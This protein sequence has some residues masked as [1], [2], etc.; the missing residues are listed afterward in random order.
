LKLTI[1]GHTGFIGSYFLR[2]Q[3]SEN[4]Q[5]VDK[6]LLNTLNKFHINADSYAIINFIGKA[7]DHKNTNLV[8]EYY[9]VNTKLSNKLFDLFL[10]SNANVFITLS[11]VKAAADV[12]FDTILTEDHT[13]NPNTHYGKSKLL[14]EEYILSKKIPTGKRVYILRPCMIHGPGNKGNLNLLYKIVIKGFPWPLGAFENKRS[15]CS[16]DNLYF[17]INELIKNDQ[18]NSGIYNISDDEVISTN[19]LIKLISEIRCKPALILN[20]PK[21]IIIFLSKIGDIFSLSLNTERLGKLTES[22]VVSN[23]KIKNAINKP[24]PISTKDGLIKTFQSFKNEFSN[25]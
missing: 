13:P 8:N 18:I 19:E 16:I 2:F 12:L 3:K 23:Q 6:N 9:E 22:Y 24:F 17:V 4:I 14:A 7:H 5:L 21:N 25:I 11:S 10:E 15:F 1:F 20:I